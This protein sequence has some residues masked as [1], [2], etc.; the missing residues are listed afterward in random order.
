MCSKDMLLHKLNVCMLRS[1]VHHSI[2][3]GWQWLEFRIR[4]LLVVVIVD[5]TLFWPPSSH[6]QFINNKFL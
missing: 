5:T 1:C 3:D 2:L 6:L 4:T